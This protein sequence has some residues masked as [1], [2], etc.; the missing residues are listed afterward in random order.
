MADICCADSMMA[1]AVE[2]LEEHGISELIAAAVARITREKPAD[3]LG[4]IGRDV[5]CHEGS[6]GR[7]EIGEIR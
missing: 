2:Y 5:C 6:G 1:S 4:E 3:P 7:A